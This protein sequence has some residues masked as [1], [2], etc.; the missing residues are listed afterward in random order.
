MIEEISGCHK[1]E[2]EIENMRNLFN[3]DDNIHKSEA[4]KSIKGHT[5]IFR[6]VLLITLYFVVLGSVFQKLDK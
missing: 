5:Y 6:D 3:K 4:I 2:Y 1:I